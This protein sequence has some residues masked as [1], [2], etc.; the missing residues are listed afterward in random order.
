MRIIEVN[1][2]DFAIV[3]CVTTGNGFKEGFFYASVSTNNG[4]GV[5]RTNE[6]GDIVTMV[7]C[8]G[9]VG[10]GDLNNFDNSGCP[11]FE[12]ISEEIFLTDEPVIF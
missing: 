2:C 9:G 10:K 11:S 5:H 12:F 8:N 1:K 7:C 4:I 3:K 6:Q